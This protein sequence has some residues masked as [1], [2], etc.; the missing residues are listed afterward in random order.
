MFA[1]ME[2]EYLGWKRRRGLTEAEGEKGGGGDCERENVSA[3]LL[4]LE[5]SENAC[6]IIAVLCLPQQEAN[7]ESWRRG[8]EMPD[9]VK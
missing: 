8:A 9:A 5:L 4:C 1:I 3:P 7:T 6:A 2:A